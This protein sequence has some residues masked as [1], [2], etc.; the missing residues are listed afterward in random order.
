MYPDIQHQVVN[1]VPD[2]ALGGTALSTLI[3]FHNIEEWLA[4]VMA[5]GGLILLLLR[6]GVAIRE[7]R[8]RKSTTPKE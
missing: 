1:A 5:F 2:V 6:I 8:K 4:V 7:L 3:W